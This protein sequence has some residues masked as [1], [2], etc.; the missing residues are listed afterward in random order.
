M[1]TGVGAQIFKIND[2]FIKENEKERA[3]LT[4]F[5]WDTLYRNAILY[6]PGIGIILEWIWDNIDFFWV[7]K[8]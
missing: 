4:G 2:P 5:I 7:K 1:L 6:F 3:L 8:E